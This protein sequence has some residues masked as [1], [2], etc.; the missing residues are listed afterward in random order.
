MTD[1]QTTPFELFEEADAKNL[2]SY[3]AI[4]T[5]KYYMNTT[6]IMNVLKKQIYPFGEEISVSLKSKKGEKTPAVRFTL[7]NPQNENLLD[8]FDYNIYNAISTLVSVG[9]VFLTIDQIYRAMN[10]DNGSKKASKEQRDE[11]QRRMQKMNNI[12][13]DA[14]FSEHYALNKIQE[15]IMS[16]E[17]TPLLY[18]EKATKKLN[19]II[20]DGYLFPMMPILYRYAND[21]GHIKTIKKELLNLSHDS[22]K[23]EHRASNTTDR[24]S[25]NTYCIERI[26]VL[27][28][29]GQKTGTI[30]LQSVYEM[31]ERVKQKKLSDKQKKTVR[32]NLNRIILPQLVDKKEVKNAELDGR[33]GKIK[34]ELQ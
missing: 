8:Q 18:F 27:R 22:A 7:S 20:V 4:Q 33:R 10:G 17:K 13:I 6:K 1:K 34:I 2:A 25:I 3:K 16:I 14:D 31:L 29:T 28:Q 26:H 21:V 19:G 30:T 12:K 5:D 15:G 24:D 11:I 9:N 32:E 23:I